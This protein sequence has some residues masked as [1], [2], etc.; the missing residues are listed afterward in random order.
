MLIYYLSYAKY[1]CIGMFVISALITLFAAYAYAVNAQRPDDDPEKREFRAGAL[2]LVFFT[3]P[4][5]IPAIISLFI[6][7][8]FFY[9]F[10]LIVFGFFLM[11]IPREAPKLTWVE[12]KMAGLGE[13]LLAANTFLLKL[14]LRPW[15]NEPEAA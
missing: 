7:R 2:V 4:L 9:A 14:M 1:L 5:L 15:T 13:A 11:I 6:V 8:V 10:F 12:R 3:W